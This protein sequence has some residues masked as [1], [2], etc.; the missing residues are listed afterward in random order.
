M[1]SG[2]SHKVINKKPTYVITTSGIL[3]TKPYYC[4]SVSARQTYWYNNSKN[5]A[6]LWFGNR[7]ADPLTHWH[8]NLNKLQHKQFPQKA[9]LITSAEAGIALPY[10]TALTVGLIIGPVGLSVPYSTTNEAP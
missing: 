6:R 9:F 7:Q 8:N 1:T 10:K 2:G 3:N 4:V 5:A